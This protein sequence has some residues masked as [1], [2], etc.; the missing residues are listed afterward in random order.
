MNDPSLRYCRLLI[1]S[2]IGS[3]RKHSKAA[4]IGGP[5]NSKS[6]SIEIPTEFAAIL[7]LP[8]SNSTFLYLV[9]TPDGYLSSPW[10]WES[11][12]TP[13]TD[14][15]PAQQGNCRQQTWPSRQSR[16]TPVISILGISREVFSRCF[17]SSPRN[18]GNCGGEIRWEHD[19]VVQ[20]R[21]DSARA[22]PGTRSAEPSVSGRNT[23]GK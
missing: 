15:L 20:L 10:E 8:A 14:V 17:A 3:F 19:A 12:N 6:S 7:M 9:V 13:D 18:S 16:Q 5:Q 22:V 21:N 1:H 4:R 23:C 2:W 11:E